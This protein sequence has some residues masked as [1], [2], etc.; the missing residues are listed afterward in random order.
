M[1]MKPNLWMP[2]GFYAL[3]SIWPEHEH[4]QPAEPDVIKPNGFS[5][6]IDLLEREAR[7]NPRLFVVLGQEMFPDLMD[8]IWDGASRLEGAE[9]FQLLSRHGKEGYRWEKGTPWNH[10][11]VARHVKF[12][13]AFKG[14]ASRDVVDMYHMH[15]DD[16]P[17]LFDKRQPDVAIVSISPENTEGY[18]SLG[19]DAGLVDRAV[20][21]AR[22]RIGIMNMHS[23]RFRYV[24]FKHA[25]ENIES[26]CR[27]KLSD[28]HHVVRV[29]HEFGP[30]KTPELSA[31]ALRMAKG[32]ARII[33]NGA[34]LQAGI[35]QSEISPDNML[36][37]E[38]YRNHDGLRAFAELTGKNA[39]EIALQQGAGDIWTSFL[40][41]PHS[42]VTRLGENGDIGRR[43]VLLPAEQMVNT[44]FIVRHVKA[45]KGKLFS[46]ASTLEVDGRGAVASAGV[47]T[48]DISGAG[49]A[50]RYR[51]AALKTGGDCI[52]VTD[53][54]RG[55]ES[56][57]VSTFKR[58]TPA[59]MSVRGPSRIATPY[60]I[61]DDL[62]FML[63]P[64]RA[65]CM[66]ML[67]APE[68]RERLA[69]NICRDYQYASLDLTWAADHVSYERLGV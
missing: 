53:A 55:T 4:T 56:R 66:V 46:L 59:T 1:Y 39:A 44:Q 19:L 7:A 11:E 6:I 9:F 24:E 64:K 28:F 60:G 41:G 5:G 20:R 26:G 49:G 25:G 61:T 35:G 14:A 51:D 45:D 62:Y 54:V 27:F 68:H 23:P 69:S 52:I 22:I 30:D 12:S 50:W 37:P 58:G 18:V 47:G 67:A 48:K 3:N 57:I 43:L 29:W 32:I 10:P 40:A 16:V 21:R 13:T 65:A 15:L 34:F 42:Y 8:H 31:S 17:Y 63:A 33:P 36:L 2:F 38:L